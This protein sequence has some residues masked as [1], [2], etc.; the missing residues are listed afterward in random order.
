MISVH[1]SCKTSDLQADPRLKAH[2]A[3]N[4]RFRSLIGGRLQ[5]PHQG[6]W[7]FLV[8]IPLRSLIL[9]RR[10]ADADAERRAH[11]GRSTPDSQAA[12]M[13]PLHFSLPAV[14]KRYT[15]LELLC[16]CVFTNTYD[17]HMV[18]IRLSRAST[19]SVADFCPMQ[20]YSPHQGLFT[21]IDTV[22]VQRGGGHFGARHHPG[23]LGDFASITCRLLFG[24]KK[25]NTHSRVYLFI[26]LHCLFV[27]VDFSDNIYL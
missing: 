17:S 1:L 9:S 5:A 15:H 10:D 4:L 7:P 19:L 26:L 13:P 21:P 12:L 16:V 23:R 3:F 20:P 11:S 24:E 14:R 8:S 22:A 2:W 25:K 27:C 6:A 18:P